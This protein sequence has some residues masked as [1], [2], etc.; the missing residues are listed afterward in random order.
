M[1][2]D[3]GKQFRMSEAVQKHLAGGK[4]IRKM[5]YASKCLPG[6]GWQRLT[7]TPHRG[8]VHV[9][10]ALADHFEPSSMPGE[11]AGY[12]PRQ[13]QEKRIETW[14]AEY[15]KNFEQ[16]RDSEGRLFTHTYF[17]PAEQYDRG[18]IQRLAG[19]C[20][21]GWGEI[22]IHLHH[23][24][25]KAETADSTRRELVSFRDTLVSRH[26]CLAYEEG[27]RVPKYAFVH[28]NF[29]LANCAGGYACGV[30]SE[31]QVLAETGCYVDMTYPTATFHPAQIAKINSLYECSLPLGEIAPQRRG[32]DLKV[33]RNVSKFPFIIQG[34]WML[35]LDWS[36]R[37]G[38][39]RIENA[40][41]TGAHPPTLRRLGL[42]KK[43][44]ITVVGRPDWLFI[45]LHTHGM[46]P[47][48]TDTTLRAPMQH[49]LKELILGAPGRGEILHFVSAREMANVILAACEGRE[50]SPGDY[51][52]Y[53]YKLLRTAGA[54]PSAMSAEL[55]VRE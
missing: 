48:Q 9:I 40:S 25:T 30:N 26:R 39:G 18:L 44:G 49:F 46:D 14:C 1:A 22:E 6:Y 2:D 5:N 17:Y 21:A 55:T 16:F 51:R 35:D 31:M 10:I 13:V 4:L 36:S 19:F 12:A 3:R 29:A 43:A 54:N 38:F 23:G 45:K 15:P 24:V 42:W 53:R 33:G 20:H 41:L 47:T 7:R 34:P 28:G 37:A 27:D 8:R 11:G 52:D 50:G 32:R